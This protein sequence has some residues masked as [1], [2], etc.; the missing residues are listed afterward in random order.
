MSEVKSGNALDAGGV[1]A[2][3]RLEKVHYTLRDT[4]LLSLLV[5]VQALRVEEED[6]CVGEFFLLG[7]C[8]LRLQSR[9]DYEQ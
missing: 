6:L 8:L 9:V 5:D 4:R 3:E 7:L 1:V 2:S